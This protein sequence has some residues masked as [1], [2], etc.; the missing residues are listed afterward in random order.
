MIRRRGGRLFALFA[1]SVA[2]ILLLVAILYQ[3]Y[4]LWI[5]HRAA[6]M[7]LPAN[8]GN[9]DRNLA[10]AAASSASRPGEFRFAVVG[11]PAAR[12][13]FINIVNE[14]N[15][16]K[17]D[18]AVLLGDVTRSDTQGDHKD[19]RYL[20]GARVH[21][22]HPMLYVVGNHDLGPGGFKLKDWEANYGRHQCYFKRGANLF[23]ISHVP[24][25]KDYDGGEG[26]RYLESVL[27]REAQSARRIFVLNHIPPACG[28]EWSARTLQD[29]RKLRDLLEKYRVDYLITGDYHS[30]ARIQKGPTTILVSGGGGSRVKGGRFGFHHAVVFSVRDDSVQERICAVPRGSSFGTRLRYIALTE[31]APFMKANAPLMAA[32][33]AVGL[34]AMVLFI[35]VLIGRRCRPILNHLSHHVPEPT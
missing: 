19:V 13:T 22:G 2:I 9:S 24:Q 10:A 30:Y 32:L 31:M 11:D 28:F 6:D 4:S 29:D 17:L 8:F 25:V 3:T 5:D 18:F 26:I 20:V 7:E 21:T 16:L 27:Q 14:L 35:S 15:T 23:I 1:S 34:L 33:D 12:S